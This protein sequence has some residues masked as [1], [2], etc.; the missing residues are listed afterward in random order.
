MR[1][2]LTSRVELYKLQILAGQA[3]S[4]YHCISISSTSVGRCAAEIGSSIAPGETD[5]THSDKFSRAKWF[6]RLNYK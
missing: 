1:P 3:S 4:G 2:F 5:I 6:T